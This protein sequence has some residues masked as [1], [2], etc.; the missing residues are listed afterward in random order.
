MYACVCAY[1]V[2]MI[3]KKDIAKRLT[4]SNLLTA[5]ESIKIVE[6]MF[7]YIKESLERGEDVS[8]VGFGK[9]YLYEHTPRPVRNPK[10]GQPMTLVPYKSVKFKISDKIKRKLK[11]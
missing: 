5:K 8:I 11:R 7:E 9:F 10:T 6:E 3:N 2:N 4:E 1:E